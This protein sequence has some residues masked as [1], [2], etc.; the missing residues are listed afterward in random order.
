MPRK[1]KRVS[2]KGDWTTEQMANAIRAV[3]RGMKVR[4]ACKRFEVPRST[5]RDRIGTESAQPPAL[6]RSAIMVKDFE[7][8]L[9]ERIVV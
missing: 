4:E 1:Y 3:T 6:S 9:A 7:D 8:E 2:N 5:L